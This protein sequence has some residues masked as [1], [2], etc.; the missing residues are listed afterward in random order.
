MDNGEAN[1]SF[2]FKTG[3]EKNNTPE[4][5]RSNFNELKSKYREHFPIYTD[6]SR[7]NNKTGY[8]VVNEICRKKM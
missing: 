1:Y 6:G 4:I 2:R 3:Q 5:H 7:D 8:S